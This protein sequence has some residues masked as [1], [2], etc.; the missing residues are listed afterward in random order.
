[1]SNHSLICASASVLRGLQIIVKTIVASIP[2]L[3]NV[4]GLLL[5]LMFVFGVL[6]TTLFGAV[7]VEYSNLGYSMY[8]L[9][10]VV[11][12]DGW[13]STSD[14][15]AVRSCDAFTSRKTHCIFS[16]APW[17]SCVKRDLLCCVCGGGPL[18]P[19][20]HGGRYHC[21]QHAGG[22]HCAMSNAG[23]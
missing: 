6:G 4:M 3:A 8:S 12:Q 20:Q 1:M 9:F 14:L 23:K 11:T 21:H 2:D 17:L 7:V 16:E 19:V 15:F 18:G 10:Q 22:T 13:A 5:I